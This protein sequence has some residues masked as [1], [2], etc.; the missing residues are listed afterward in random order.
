MQT[1][2][3]EHGCPTSSLG[4]FLGGFASVAGLLTGGLLIIQGA[5]LL[6]RQSRC[7]RSKAQGLPRFLWELP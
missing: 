4:L 3:Q 1:F 7:F 2:R 6:L 5:L